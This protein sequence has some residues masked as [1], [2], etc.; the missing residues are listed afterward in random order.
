MNC[1]EGLPGVLTTTIEAV[2]YIE[3]LKID[4]LGVQPD[5]YHMNVGEASIP[6]AVRTAGRY[7]KHYHF[8]ETNHMAHGTG[9][10][11]FR[12]IIV[13]ILKEIGYD[14]YLC[15]YLPQTSQQIFQSTPGIGTY[16]DSATKTSDRGGE[17]KRFSITCLNPFVYYRKLNGR[18]NWSGNGTNWTRRGT[19]VRPKIWL[20]IGD[21]I[22]GIG[23]ENPSGMRVRLSLLGSPG[24]APGSLVCRHRAI[25]NWLF[26]KS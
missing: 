20:S 3:E 10:A 23:D 5:N 9:H 7:I 14:A 8:N 25:R 4:N 18:L 6:Q 2:N 15:F 11:N 13:R 19:E 16:G 22:P 21:W 24:L 12:D 1:Y 17:E 26:D